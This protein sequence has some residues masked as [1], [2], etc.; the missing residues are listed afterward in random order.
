MLAFAG[1]PYLKRERRRRLSHTSHRTPHTVLV[2][3]R[4]DIIVHPHS[5]QTDSRLV[6]R[7]IER[8]TD[9]EQKTDRKK[10]RQT[11][12]DTHK[13]TS[14]LVDRQTGKTERLTPLKNSPSSVTVTV[15]RDSSFLSY[16]YN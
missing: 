16:S 1:L 3:A 9:R 2:L 5:F 14:R 11:N 15:V 8:Q 6:D 7:H 13:Q 12:S 4:K 10:G